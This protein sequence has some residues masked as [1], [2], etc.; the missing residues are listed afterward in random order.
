MEVLSGLFW[1]FYLLICPAATLL[2]LFIFVLKCDSVNNLALR[3]S[4]AVLVLA[5]A[6]GPIWTEVG[7]MP[8]WVPRVSPKMLNPTI[9]LQ[10]LIWQYAAVC[11][12]TFLV[13]G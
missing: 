2:V 8:W 5:F 11:A 7:L 13:F 3:S 9:D 1:F 12:V 10:Y 6:L 4:V